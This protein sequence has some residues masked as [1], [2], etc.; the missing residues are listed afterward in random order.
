MLTLATGNVG[1]IREFEAMLAPI[2]CVAAANVATALVETGLSF[3]ENAILKARHVSARVGGPVLADDSGLMVSALDDAPGIYS[4]RF[5]GEHA[6]DQDNLMKLLDMLQDVPLSHRQARFYC[7]LAIVRHPHDPAPMIA[8]GQ[9]LGVIRLS[10][11]GDRGFGYDPVFFLP[12]YGSTF[13]ELAP[14][15]KN[16]ISHRAIALKKLRSR[17]HELFE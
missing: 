8:E 2:R 6:D 11:Q 12:E 5:A 7:A 1:K 15:L 4:A 17:I 13:A 16:Q 3:V 9:C 10:P 14:E